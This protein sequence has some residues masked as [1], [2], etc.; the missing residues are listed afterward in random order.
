MW[1]RLYNAEKKVYSLGSYK[2]HYLSRLQQQRNTILCWKTPQVN[3][4]ANSFVTVEQ[5]A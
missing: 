1:K 5:M 2:V 3:L 4:S